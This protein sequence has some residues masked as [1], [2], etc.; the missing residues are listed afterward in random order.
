MFFEDLTQQDFAIRILKAHIEKKRLAHTYVFSGKASSRKEDLA[1]A[2]ACA[3]NGEQE[4]LF[5]DYHTNACKKIS[6]HNH[7]DVHW[8]G[9]DSK[10]KSLKIEE[11]RTLISQAGYK[12]Y[13]GSWKLFVIMGADRLTVDA[14]NALLK[15]L[16]E[17]PEQT[18]F[19]ML[20]ESKSHLLETIQ[21]RSFEIRL[22]P[23]ED[24][25]PIDH[26]EFQALADPARVDWPEY[27]ESAQK[28]TREDTKAYLE[29]LLDFFQVYLKESVHDP[30]RL[31]RAM[32]AADRIVETKDAIN[33]NTSQK[34]AMTRLSMQMT[35]LY[36]KG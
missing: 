31:E 3:L 1:M 19:V 25:E 27:F 23:L 9:E 21:S 14:S 26:S 7:P 33:A 20:T 22:K 17:P 30:V 36:S 15:T 16:E 24:L 13:E 34:L 4:D 8:I 18:V 5:V 2:F 12:P 35:K 10:A 29:R 32:L 6:E 28:K 11:M